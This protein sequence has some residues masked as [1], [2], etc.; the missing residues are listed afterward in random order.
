MP[1]ARRP[2]NLRGRTERDGRAAVRLPLFGHD[3]RRFGP[4]GRS[5]PDGQRS[6]A[7]ARR[8]EGRARLFGRARHLDHP[9]VA[10]DHLWLRGGHLHRRPRPGRGAGAG[11][12]EGAAARHQAAQHLH[13]GSARRVRARLRVPDV[14]G[15]RAL[16]GPV[17]AR[18]LDRAP[19]DRQEADRDRRAGRRR[20][21]RARRHRQGQR[22][23]ALRA[24]LLRAQAR[25]DGDRAMA[26]MGLALAR[27]AHRVRRAAP[28]PDRQGQAGRGA[29][30]GRRQPA[31][32]LLRGEGAGR[33]RARGAGLRL[34]AHARS[35][36]RRPIGRRYVSVE[37]ER[38]DAVGGRT[39][40]GCRRRACWPSSTGSDASTASAG[41]IWSRTASSA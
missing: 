8:E 20:C 32:R 6:R 40:S 28:D 24:R 25:R 27:G 10:A 23:G 11:A 34:F 26:G 17:S 35:A 2:C 15:E 3:I 38:G 16:R 14:P 18:H 30:L 41:S 7:K 12:Q 22:P 19:A 37:F 36:S 4:V 31:A 33:P 9:E 13:R 5:D 39:A 21:G 1:A 29:V